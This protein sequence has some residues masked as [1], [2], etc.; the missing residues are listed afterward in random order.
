MLSFLVALQH[1]LGEVLAAY[2]RRKKFGRVGLE[3]KG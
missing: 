3:K 1:Q 2:L